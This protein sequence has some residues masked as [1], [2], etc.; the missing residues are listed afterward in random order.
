MRLPNRAALTVA[1][2]TTILVVLALVLAALPGGLLL[3]A[4]EPNLELHW[5]IQKP[6]DA[7]TRLEDTSGFGRDATLTGG[8]T[9]TTDR[10][11]NANSALSFDGSNDIASTTAVSADIALD[12]VTMLS[13]STWVNTSFTTRMHPFV[14][15]LF[16]SQTRAFYLGRGEWV[17]TTPLWGCNLNQA[18]FMIDYRGGKKCGVCSNVAINDG[19]WHHLVGVWEQSGSTLRQTNFKLYVDGIDS[20][21]ASFIVGG[22][23]FCPF[24]LEPS[25][26]PGFD[27]YAAYAGHASYWGTTT[28]KYLNG[29]LDDIRFYRRALSA[30]EVELLYDRGTIVGDALDSDAFD[31][32]GPSVAVYGED[33][34]YIAT[35]DAGVGVPIDYTWYYTS[36]VNAAATTDPIPNGSVGNLYYVEAL[37]QESRANELVFTWD[38]MSPAPLVPTTRIISAT[39]LNGFSTLPVTKTRTIILTYRPEVVGEIGTTP[40]IADLTID[41]DT[42]GMR[43]FQVQDKDLVGTLALTGV[44]EVKPTLPDVSISFSNTQQINQTDLASTIVVAPTADAWGTSVITVSASDGFI[45]GTN[46]FAL[47]VLPVNDPPSFVQGGS[48]TVTENS[49]IY[50]QAAW[51]KTVF[52]GPYELD[53]AMWF[54]LTTDNPL[55]FSTSPTVTIVTQ[56]VI[57]ATGKMTVTNLTAPYSG[58]LM[59]E[60]ALTRYGTAVVTATLLDNG[61]TDRNGSN[62]SAQ[63]VFTITVLES[64]TITTT[65]DTPRTILPATMLA[66]KSDPSEWVYTP[67]LTSAQNGTLTVISPTREVIY[68]PPQDFFGNDVFT[69]TMRSSTI[70]ETVIMRVMVLPVND[71]PMFTRGADQHVPVNAGAQTVDPWATGISVGPTNEVSQTVDFLLSHDQP[72]LFSAQPYITRTGTLTFTPALDAR[73]AVTVTVR[74]H[75]DG[76]T[77]YD[78][79]DTSDPQTFLIEIGLMAPQA[80]QDSYTTEMNRSLTIPVSGLLANDTDADGDT[81]TFQQASTTTAQGG[82]VSFSST[83]TA[84]LTYTPPQDYIGA[85]SFSYTIADPTGLQGTGTVLI[86]VTEIGGYTMYLPVVVR[87]VAT[88]A[89]LVVTSFTLAPAK[90]SYAAGEAVVVNVTIA[91]QGDTSATDFWVDFFINP[92]E[93]PDSSNLIWD[94]L[95][96]LTPCYG[97][98]WAVTEPLAPGESMTLTSAGPSTSTPNGYSADYTIWPGGFA[99]GTTDLYVYVDTWDQSD[100][101]GAVEEVQEDNN[102]SHMQVS[103]TGSA[104]NLSNDQRDVSDLPQRP[105]RP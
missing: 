10:D 73:G 101:L 1:L 17:D 93:V 105:P 49:G 30:A 56:S 51:A 43:D 53:Q 77:D 79:V 87:T 45:T 68:T 2:A 18:I 41:E 13:I 42:W 27:I 14:T 35:V 36:E 21:N 69:Y 15:A 37:A 92:S 52:P 40:D 58:T 102:L 28:Y 16:G 33:T 65:E 90:S 81:I 44:V 64:N 85:D 94:D 39:A 20:T 31:I 61:G 19:N 97:I 24:S 95:C 3:A 57:S 80:V 98:V 88:Q 104:V 91:N 4:G 55:L 47:D 50:Q 32:V 96:T 70:T 89:D 11:G 76:G 83:P 54:T 12:D 25:E 29:S 22:E 78:G 71:P 62:I 46:T 86:N 23:T 26:A 99:S 34:S 59:F 9:W 7:N 5:D 100:P 84:T 66:S 38:D 48:I 82:T 75:D 6:P 74:L 72:D 67:T 60:P 103:V 8:V 63:E